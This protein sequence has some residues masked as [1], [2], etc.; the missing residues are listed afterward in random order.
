ANSAGSFTN[1]A[2]VT[3]STATDTNSA[4]NTASAAVTVRPLRADLAVSKTASTNLIK[5]G[6]QVSF[7]VTVTNLG[8]DIVTNATIQD[9]LP[10]GLGYVFS[11]GPGTYNPGTGGWNLNFLSPGSVASLT[12]SAQGNSPG[13]YLNTASVTFSTATDTN[14]AN[15]SAGAA[16]TVRPVQAD[17]AVNKTASV[18]SVQTSNQFSYTITV[19]NLGP[20]LVTNATVEDVLPAG[21]T[22]ISSMGAGT[23]NVMTGGW[24]IF[25]LSP[26]GVASLTITVQANSGGNYTNTATI[27]SS[28]AQDTNALNN[29]S[30]AVVMN[31]G[32][33]QADL[34]LTKTASTNAAQ[35]GQQVVFTLVLTN[36]GPAGITNPIVTTDCLPGGFEYVTDSTY[37]NT[38]NGSYSPGTCW[39]TLSGLAANARATLQITVL[40]TNSGVYTNIATVAVPMGVNDPNLGNNTASCVVTNLSNQADLAI[41]KS[42]ST[43]SVKIGGQ[44]VFTLVLTNIGPVDVRSTITVTDC[45]PAGFEYVTD[46]TVGGTNNNGIYSPGTCWWTLPGLAANAS[47]S[48][49]ITVQAITNGVFTNVA[50]VGVPSGITD[51]VTNNNTASAV[52]TNRLPTADLSITKGGST[53]ATQTGQ[54]VTFTISLQNLGPDDVTNQIV[55]QDCLPAGLDYVTDSTYGGGGIGTYSPG[56]CLWTLP[57][58][59]AAN[60]TVYLYITASGNTNVGSFTNTAYVPVPQ[61]IFD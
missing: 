16:V 4:N 53:S 42:A 19:T 9:S 6:D 10:P 23:Y 18:N 60:A 49:D 27:I 33:P 5:V 38:N 41:S 15:N 36:P 56:T 48:L 52:V 43:N 46:S 31:S 11:S 3:F 57:N 44:V 50:V 40:A 26:G 34:S 13:A 12:I 54:Q 45:L 21:L 39:W 14:S 30:T 7:T 1:T 58:G 8:P 55:V 61:G 32:N 28:T 37:G 22:Y 17:L 59:L 2:S 51:P 20:D 25:Y 35:I 29:S 47:Q 24:D